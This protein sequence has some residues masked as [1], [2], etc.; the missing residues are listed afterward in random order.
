M[1]QY[2]F[3]PNSPI[4][5]VFTRIEGKNNTIRRPRLAVDTGA[6][7]CMIPWELANAL[8]LEPHISHEKISITTASGIVEAPL[9]TLPSVD[10]FGS[11]AT[12]IKA[13]VHDLPTQSCV[14][15]LLGLSFL[16][17][18]KVI[19]DFKNGLLEIV[20]YPATI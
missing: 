16:K 1:A 6:T 3:P 2:R 12:N 13:V 18:F 15:G 5:T 19:L 11:K 20:S 10:V 7:Y 4:I 14:D 9:V 8:M 17:N